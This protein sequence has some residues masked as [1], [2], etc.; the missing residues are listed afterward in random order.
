MELLLEHG[1][2]LLISTKS[3]IPKRFISLF[4]EFSDLVHVQVG[5]T[6]VD[7]EIRKLI[8]PGAFPVEKRL[9]SIPFLIANNIS[10]ELRIDPLIPGL[11]DM[12]ESFN[13]LCESAA[14]KG[15]TSA[16]VSYLFIRQA[17]LK[18]M[19]V[20]YKDWAF[21]D[22]LRSLFTE[23]IER[24]CGKSS[25]LVADTE[26]RR[27]SYDILHEIAGHYGLKLRMCQCKNPDLTTE[28]CHPDMSRV[29]HNVGQ[30]NLFS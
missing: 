10:V 3:Q 13:M 23:K 24:Y 4:A 26:Y 7:D 21:S 19:N 22:V 18:S 1:I 6:T 8:E 14:I 11:T 16:A 12:E 15:I 29:N 30:I 5:L 20:T 17:M 9:D 2:A 25:I 27:R 28:C